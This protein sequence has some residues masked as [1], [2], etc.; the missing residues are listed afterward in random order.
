MREV[1]HLPLAYCEPEITGNS[2]CDPVHRLSGLAFSIKV[3][4]EFTP[5]ISILWQPIDSLCLLRLV[6]ASAG[7]QDLAV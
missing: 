7:R 3:I 6:A 4:R 5:S 2:N 1:L